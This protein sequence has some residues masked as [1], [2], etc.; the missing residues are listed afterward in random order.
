[1]FRAPAASAALLVALSASPAIAGDWTGVYVGAGTSFTRH[2]V[3]FPNGTDTVTMTDTTPPGVGTWSNGSGTL[4]QTGDSVGGH[5]LGG[6]R[7]QWNRFVL[8][9]E[10]DYE[11][12]SRFGSPLPPGRPAC[13]NGFIITS[14]HAGC[15]GLGVY[16]SDV[17]TLGHV[18][19][20]VGY[21]LTPS[22]LGFIA[23][24]LAIGR[25]PDSISARASGIVVANPSAPLAG[26]ATVTRSGIGET[27][28]GYTIG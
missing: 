13:Q 12:N 2:N 14:G 21:E 4:D 15:V 3:W 24:G 28:Y 17:T 1:M 22:M 5:I 9:T 10:A 27:I 25:S 19:G 8:G 6:V 18:R 23:G 26:Q 7:Y 20:T 16:F 11:F